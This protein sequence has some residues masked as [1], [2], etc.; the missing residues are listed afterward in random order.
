MSNIYTRGPVQG[1][2]KSFLLATILV[3]HLVLVCDIETALVQRYDC[4]AQKLGDVVGIGQSVSIFNLLS[5]LLLKFLT[6]DRIMLVNF[7]D[8]MSRCFNGRIA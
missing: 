2:G 7:K 1:C 8:W 3:I 5:N 4:K 6:N